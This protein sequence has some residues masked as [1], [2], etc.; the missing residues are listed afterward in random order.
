MFDLCD[1]DW[2]LWVEGEL[3]LCAV[4]LWQIH[5]PEKFA[6][7]VKRWRDK[8]PE[9]LARYAREQRA[10]DPERARQAWREWREE[11][12]ER[13]RDRVRKWKEAN[14]V[15]T[16]EHNR[17][18]GKRRRARESGAIG[19]HTEAQVAE[20]FGRQKGRCA[21]CRGKL[22]KENKHLDHI[23]PLSRGGSDNVSNLQWLCQ[24]CNQRKHAKD[25]LAWAREIG[26]L[27]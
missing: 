1:E 13:D 18:G 19:S 24:P 22:T 5:N 10:L 6:V 14:H 2:F 8:N 16:R 23:R 17:S 21:Y 7:Q 11:N 12:K 15:K 3:D 4:R 20:L 25:P 26:L 27:L 9:K